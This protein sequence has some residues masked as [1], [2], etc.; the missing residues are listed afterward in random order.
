LVKRK[1]FPSVGENVIVTVTRIT[2]YSAMCALDEYPKKE[3]MIHVSEV[4]GKWVRDI[5]NYV[6]MNKSYVAKVIRLDEERGHINLSLKRVPKQAKDRKLQDF[7]HEQKAEK[8]LEVVGKKMKLTLDEAYDKIGF[9]LQDK[10]GDMFKAFN[11]GFKSPD[12][13][14]R[15]GID[16]KLAKV[17][18]EVAKEH[19]KLKEIKIKAELD[20][21]YYTGDGVKRVKKFL[22]E[23]TNKY[24]LSV[25]YISAPKYSIETKSKDPKASQQLLRKTLTEAVA[26]V[27]KEGVASFKIEGEK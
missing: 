5:R 19:I 8:Y 18:H 17:I 25:N 20:L 26:T 16:E 11:E 12:P 7:K 10:F 4:T 6:K 1:G 23:L 13:L 27:G 2:P 14:V 22:T 24:G 21:T 15:R 3:G 9:E